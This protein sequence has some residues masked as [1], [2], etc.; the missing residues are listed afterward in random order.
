[1]GAIYVWAAV[2]FS[3]GPSLGVSGSGPWNDFATTRLINLMNFAGP[4]TL[5]GGEVQLGRLSG[6]LT[7]MTLEGPI[8][9]AG[10]FTVPLVIP[11]ND[12][13]TVGASLSKLNGSLFFA[14]I[15]SVQ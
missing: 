8:F 5:Q 2:G 1:M 9:Q 12:G 11:F 10:A 3:V 6:G 13:Q 7:L 15:I 4:M 14:E